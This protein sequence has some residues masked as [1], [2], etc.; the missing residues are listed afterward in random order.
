MQAD[1]LCIKE[2][3][4]SAREDNKSV[5][6]FQQRQLDVIQVQPRYNDRRPK[7]VIEA[8]TDLFGKHRKAQKRIFQSCRMSEHVAQAW[9]FSDSW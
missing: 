7:E 9:T 8:V 4:R 3:L 2:D 5:R 1:V 6:Q